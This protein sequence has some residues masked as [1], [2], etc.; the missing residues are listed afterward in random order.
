ME[1]TKGAEAETIFHAA[2]A[3]GPEERA[4]FLNSACGNNVQ[5]R[6]RV[7]GLL[8]AYE[9]PAGFLP[10]QPGSGPENPVSPAISTEQPGDRIGHYKLLQK[11]GEGGCGVV[12][13]AQQIFTFLH[14]QY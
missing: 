8:H 10:D 4:A 3:L 11:L 12:Y 1:S 5:L 2:L 7:G 13:M 6:N 14:R 9:A